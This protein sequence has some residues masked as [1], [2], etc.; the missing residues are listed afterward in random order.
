MDTGSIARSPVISTPT[1]AP[2]AAVSAGGVAT[3]LPA[4]AVVRQIGETEAVR[5]EPSG[6]AGTRA[7]I[8]AAAQDLRRQVIID[9][10]TRDLVFQS[11]NDRTG[12]VVRQIPDETL[13][14]LRAYVREISAKEADGVGTKVEKIG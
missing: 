6:G 2:A 12:E 7:A 14:R 3:E 13:L 9:P 10:E 4:A 5:F 11:V 1:A 8:E